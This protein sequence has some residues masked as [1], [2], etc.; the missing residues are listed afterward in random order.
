MR[1]ADLIVLVVY[2]AAV[3]ALGCSLARRSGTPKGFMTAGGRLGGWAVGLSLFG[4]FLSSNTFL[5]VPGKAFAE[6]WNSWVFSLSLPIAAWVASRWFVPFYREAGHL[7]AYEHFE[8]RFGRWART[9]AVVCYLLTQLARVGS[10]LFG[11]ALALHALTGWP[12]AAI[13]VA[14]GAL[15]TLYTLIGGIEAVIWTDVVQSV[16]LTAGAVLVVATL[17]AGTPGGLS[18]ILA[19]AGEA[20]KTGLG[21]FEPEFGASTFWVVLL[22]GLFINLNNFGIDQS[23]VQRYHVA[24]DLAEA[25]RSVWLAAILYV[26]I[27]FAFFFIGTGLWVYYSGRPDALATVG[28]TAGVEAGGDHVFPH[29]IV[30]ELPTGISGLLIAALLAA[31]MS[32]IDTSLNSSATVLL[33]DVWT[34]YVRPSPTES[35][36]MRV[37][38][39][40]TLLVG[41]LG[42]LTAL[43]MIGVQSLLDAWWTLSGVFAGGLLGLFLLGMLVRRADRAAA[44][45][46]VAVGV[47]VIL[48]MTFP[49]YL[50]P[51]LQSPFHSNM[52]TVVGT[53]SLFLTGL[54]VTSWRT[55]SRALSR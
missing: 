32:S 21:S 37:L 36:T 55:R 40:A 16:V 20:G 52:I 39:G 26:P 11:V 18:G 48:W 53:L 27:S 22:Y 23:Y 42:T 25:R 50:P 47:A 24:R 54:V 35:A 30:N 3:V 2:V 46:A 33:E 7:S 8:A 31:A 5:G 45:A 17:V 15:V 41:T 49:A 19:A 51:G 44:L 14:T 43:A 38:H 4:T 13:I 34:P 9:Y 28:A 6:D 12:L 10:I 29:F 1:V